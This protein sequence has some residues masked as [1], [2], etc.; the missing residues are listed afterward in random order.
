MKDY[1]IEVSIYDPWANP[2]EVQH[3][4]KLVTTKEVPN[5]KFDTIVL[6]VAHKEFLELDLE[7]FK[8]E[9]SV[10]YDVKGILKGTIDGKL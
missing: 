3:E 8:K 7:I 5:Q 4:Y 1:G 9:K 2:T 6:G 10:V